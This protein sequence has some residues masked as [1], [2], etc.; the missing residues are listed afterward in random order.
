MIEHLISI[1]KELFFAINQGWSSPFLDWL[2]PI[3]RNPY[4]WAPLYLFIVIFCIKTYKMKGAFFILAIA[5]NFGLSDSISSQLVKKTVQ[6][7]RPCN[8]IEMK[9]DVQLRVRCGT[10]FSFTSSHATN[11]FAMAVFLILGFYKRWKWIL[12][13]GLLWAASISIAQ[14]YVG[15][16]YPG[17]ILA[18]TILGSLIGWISY[19]LYCRLTKPEN[20]I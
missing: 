12:P 2:M 18:G 14:V 9:E 3:L 13:L 16:H 20:R 10:G 17:D 15:V 19:N 5:L 8:D 7:I 4:T 1:D 6:R 11:H